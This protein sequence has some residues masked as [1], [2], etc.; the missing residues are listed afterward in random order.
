MYTSQNSEV[1][2]NSA[3]PHT[4]LGAGRTNG[5]NEAIFFNSR[6]VASI[7]YRALLVTLFQLSY[8]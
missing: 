8:A 6:R 2:E 7:Y 3:I 5:M 4:D 1:A